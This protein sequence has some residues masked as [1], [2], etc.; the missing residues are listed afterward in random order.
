MFFNEFINTR[1]KELGMSIDELVRRSGIP[2]GT[3]S[4]ITSGIHSNPT[5]GT[6]LA[7]CKALDC[8][9]NDMV[10]QLSQST[11]STAEMRHLKKY[12]V[13]DSYGKEAVDGLTDIEYERCTAVPEAET[14]YITLK[15]AYLAASAGTGD[16]L[17][18]EDYEHITVKRTTETEQAD[19][20]VRVNGN[21]MEPTY[22]DGDILLVEGAPYINIGDI[23]IFVVNGCGYV[24]EYGG[25]KLISHNRA[26]KDILL[27]EHDVVLCSGRVLGVLDEAV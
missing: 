16:Y 6:A 4:K 3:L 15:L 21:S 24:K 18:D 1:R 22:Y 13:L 17:S 10:G 12:R 27:H 14:E 7:L 9:L 20:A 19:F 8:T 25:H 11:V 26:Y 23:G 2:K 5:L